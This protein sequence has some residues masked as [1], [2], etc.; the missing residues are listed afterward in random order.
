MDTSTHPLALCTALV[1][2][3]LS[4]S[5]C[6]RQEPVPPGAAASAKTSVGTEIDDTVVTTKV[7]SAL[8]GDQNIKG[9]GI[10][11]E[12]RKGAVQL[13]GFADTQEQVDRAV[14][15]AKSVE[16]VAS[17]DNALKIKEGKASVGNKVD[18]SIVTA[19]VKSALISDPGVKSFDIA[20]ATNKGEVQLSGFV[21]N[22]MQIDHAVELARGVEGVQG[23]D[24]KMTL[25]K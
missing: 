24:N 20:V 18:D 14:S 9:L 23:V 25:K 11:V 2:V 16:G 8:L 12:T 3:A 17:V 22:Q 5:A 4:V 7:K 10:K 15:V 21:D 1:A 6:N 19:K 13:S